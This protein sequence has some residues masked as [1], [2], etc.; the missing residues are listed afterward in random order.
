MRLTA[1]QW[2]LLADLAQPKPPPVW[3]L[4]WY[5]QKKN[6]P[7]LQVLASL[8]YAQAGEW[9]INRY[10]YQITEAGKA[11]LATYGRSYR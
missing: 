1:A 8:G 5:F 11:K 3:D 7:T 6:L 2:R 9:D 10:G 4:Y